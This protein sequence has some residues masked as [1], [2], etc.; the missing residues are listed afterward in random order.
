MNIGTHQFEKHWFFQRAIDRRRSNIHEFCIKKSCSR[1]FANFVPCLACVLAACSLLTARCAAEKP[2]PLADAPRRCT[3]REEP[4]GWWLV[5]PADKQFFSLGICEFNQGSD[6]HDARHPSYVGSQLYDSPEA[7]ATANVRRLHQWGFTTLGAWSDYQLAGEIGSPKLWMT[8]EL[9]MLRSGAPWFDM[10]DEK[11]IHRIEELAA[12]SIAPLR[13]N[14]QVIGYYSDNE[15][16]W[17]NATLWK[18][19]LNQPATSGQRQRLIRLVREDYSNDWTALLKDFEPQNAANWDELDRGGMLWLRPGGKGTLTMRRFLGIVAERYYQLMHD[20]IHKL[21]PGALYLGDRYQS[22]Y[23]PEVAKAAGKHVDVVSTNL[24]ANWND[25]TF[26]HSYLN[27]LH[28]L[29]GKPI[30]ISEFYMAAAENSSGNKNQSSGFPVVPTQHER[31]Q[32]LTNTLR[33]VATL[34]YVIG[35]DWFQ[36]YDEP[37]KGRGDGEDYNFG[38]VDI[39]DRQYAEVTQAFAAMKPASLKTTSSKRPMDV[40]ARIPPAPADPLGRFQAMTA[41]KNWDRERGF[42]PSSTENPVGDFY[43]CWSPESLY[44]ATYVIDIAEPNGYRSGKIPE[45]DRAEWKVQVNTESPITARIGAGQNPVI[46]NPAVRI[47][48]LSG[49]DHNVRCITAIAVPAKELGKQQFEVGDHI[50]LKSFFDTLGRANHMEWNG[51]LE[52]TK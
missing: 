47:A 41:L 9:T 4:N 48:S 26:L 46:D 16:G 38:L 42:L 34:S 31:S 25:G 29:T 39:Q 52:L 3:V 40:S 33:S 24:N 19:A 2:A 5:D 1:A 30:L 10:W 14:P 20:T 17:W 23:Y 35:A 12:A 32:A 37:P 21:D 49:T 43:V 11:V 15:L 22:F 27:T 18:M 45:A 6:K 28:T 8:P 44:F 36:Y 50:S 51:E 7:W 13:G